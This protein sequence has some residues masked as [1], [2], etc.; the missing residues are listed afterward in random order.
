[1][2]S[3]QLIRIE[4]NLLD[5][6]LDIANIA[7]TLEDLY[8]RSLQPQKH[9]DMGDQCHLCGQPMQWRL[10]CPRCQPDLDLERKMRS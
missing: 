1:M 8:K 2:D 3:E 10:I 7:S 5:M 9:M 6:R 4:R